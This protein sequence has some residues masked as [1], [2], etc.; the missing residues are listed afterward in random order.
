MN[1]AV[2]QFTEARL[3]IYRGVRKHGTLSTQFKD[4]STNMVNVLRDT[5][6]RSVGQFGRRPRATVLTDII[7][8]TLAV[9]FARDKVRA[10]DPRR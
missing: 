7:D 2:S 4:C 10:L 6:K 1:Q 3:E 8:V 9:M 5:S